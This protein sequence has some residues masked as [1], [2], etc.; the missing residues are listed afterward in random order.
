[1]GKTKTAFVGETP[2]QQ[3]KALKKRAKYEAKKA[4]KKVR[5]PGLG[6]GQRVVAVE[7]E[8]P[9]EGEVALKETSALQPTAPRGKRQSGKRRGRKYLTAKANIDPTKNYP[10]EEAVKLAKET[11]YS[12]FPGRLEVHLV[13]KK[14]TFN[15]VIELPYSPGS[16]RRVEIADEDTIKKLEAGKIDF[17][18]LIAHPSMMPKLVPF[19]KFLGPRGLMPNPKSA[20]ISD[21]PEE[22]AKK[23]GGNSLQIKSEIKAPLV[24]TAIG[25]VD[26]PEKE[27]TENL[28][29]VLSEI[30]RPNIEKAVIKATMGPSIKISTV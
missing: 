3:T 10:A 26:Q 21:K 28:A 8:V 24:H 17:D 30:G 22:A 15:K 1:M 13:L 19:A 2:E 5:V 18:I 27:L 9:T 25:R 29:R 7:T 6:G 20:T 11:S 16:A 4:A 14:G 12:S 23:F